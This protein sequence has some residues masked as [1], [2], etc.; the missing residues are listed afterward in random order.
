MTP[1]LIEVDY[2]N[3]QQTGDLL[4]LLNEYAS[5][6]MGGGEPI[7]TERHSSIIAGLREFPT[8]FSFLVY[9]DRTPA[10]MTN[11]FFG[12]STFAGKRLIN[13]HDLMVSKEFRGQGLS[14]FL[15]QEI[16]AKARANDCCK[17]TLE[18]LSNNEIAKNSYRKF[19]FDGY[20]LDPSAGEAI[21]W[22]KKLS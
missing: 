22:Q 11:C 2:S 19:G 10:A 20:E 9:V 14:H 21:F 5:E 3:P 17:I 18:V 1:E 13:I 16:E 15:L 8:A 6:P 4:Q 7:A 12:F